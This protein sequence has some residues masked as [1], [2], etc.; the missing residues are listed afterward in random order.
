MAW[1]ICILAVSEAN[2][3]VY[4][5]NYHLSIYESNTAYRSENGAK[6][7]AYG[8]NGWKNEDNQDNNLHL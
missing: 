3:H 2:L 1:N 4:N 6:N 5:W 7:N 8:R